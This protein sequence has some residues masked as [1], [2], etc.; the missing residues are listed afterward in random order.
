MLAASRAQCRSEKPPRYRQAATAT[1]TTR[2]H[3]AF[4]SGA[5][6]AHHEHG[7]RR[8]HDDPPP[9][10]PP[11]PP[12]CPPSCVRPAGPRQQP[13]APQGVLLQPMHVAWGRGARGFGMRPGCASGHGA[14][15]SRGPG[16]GAGP[17]MG[18]PG[19]ALRA[20]RRCASR[21]NNRRGSPAAFLF[22]PSPPPPSI[23]MRRHR[24]GVDRQTPI[25]APPRGRFLIGLPVGRK[26]SPVR[27][28]C[29]PTKSHGLPPRPPFFSE[30]GL[31][32]K[33]KIAKPQTGRLPPQKKNEAARW[34]TIPVSWSS[35]RGGWQRTERKQH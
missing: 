30:N 20:G 14:L 22:P 18:H 16:V 9:L 3:A 28:L 6:T 12:P 17:S 11:A 32:P 5:G 29:A 27:P 23:S 31:P 15:T 33:K 24:R 21:G 13:S 34:R 26:N 2:T 8:T 1:I 35:I 19:L 10:P 4:I 25:A 7:R